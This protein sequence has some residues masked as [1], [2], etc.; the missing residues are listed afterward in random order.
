MAP[1]LSKSQP[2]S[3]SDVQKL[4]SCK[5][6]GGRERGRLSAVRQDRRWYK[7]EQTQRKEGMLRTRSKQTD[8]NPILL[9]PK[10]CSNALLTQL[11]DRRFGCATASRMTA[12][13][14]A[15]VVIARTTNVK[16]FPN[17]EVPLSPL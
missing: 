5:T 8:S 7:D 10:S 3:Y 12:V 9:S 4:D 15:A 14:S 17:N 1:T 2:H 6:N 13:I 16:M 11:H